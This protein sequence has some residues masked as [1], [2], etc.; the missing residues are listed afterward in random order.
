MGGK[1]RE[2]NSQ[3][4]VKMTLDLEP[5]ENRNSSLIFNV[6]GGEKVQPQRKEWRLALWAGAEN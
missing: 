3:P 6:P 5:L 1:G 2:A 4:L